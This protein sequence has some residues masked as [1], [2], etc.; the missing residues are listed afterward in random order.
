[1]IGAILGD[2]RIIVQ[3]TVPEFNEVQDVCPEC[4]SDRLFSDEVKGEKVCTNCGFVTREVIVSHKPEWRAFNMQERADR[5][6]VGMPRSMAIGDFGLHT[7]ISADTRF[8]K[9][10]ISEERKNQLRRMS[11]WQSRVTK[12]DKIRNLNRAMGILANLCNHLH[13][14]N[15]VK[16][17][18]AFL[19]RK[20]LKAGLIRG[21]SI[22]SIVAACLYAACRY[23][24]TQRQLKEIAKYTSIDYKELAKSYRVIYKRLNLEVPRQKAQSQVPKI[25]DKVGINPKLQSDAVSILKMAEKS[26]LT[27]G[28]SPS[29]LAAAAL[30]IA[31]SQAK[32]K[33]TQND[34]AYAAGV[35]EVTIR[36]RYKELVN[37]LDLVLDM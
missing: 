32:A 9:G 35:T 18:T 4:G 5:A 14:P 11:M 30:Y 23:N 17:Q 31:C 26:K 2:V 3:S 29:G 22:E 19:Y 27:G 15:A 13:I 34:I 20:A 37:E 7:T 12:S 36:N 8:I 25:A 24:R 10:K 6:R 16:E 21:R 33:F 28:K 1:M